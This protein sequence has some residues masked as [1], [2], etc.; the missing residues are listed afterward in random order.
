[1]VECTQEEKATAKQK[2]K[3]NFCKERLK[4]YGKQ[5]IKYALSLLENGN[6]K[7]CID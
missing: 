2:E 7:K 3:A 4:V 6:C 5:Q 1:M